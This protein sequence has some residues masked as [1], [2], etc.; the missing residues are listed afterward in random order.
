MA[1]R[2]AIRS[3]SVARTGVDGAPPV[4]V[5][6]NNARGRG[7]DYARHWRRCTR[8]GRTVG[9]T[10]RSCTRSGGLGLFGSCLDVRVKES[11]RLLA[12]S[13]DEH[14]GIP[15]YLHSTLPCGGRLRTFRYRA[16]FLRIVVLHCVGLSPQ[17]TSHTCRF[18]GLSNFPRAHDGLGLYRGVRCWCGVVQ[19]KKTIR[20]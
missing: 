4:E 11:Q 15:G 16:L 1:T 12:S 10:G 6:E 8:L 2:M 13:S 9:A 5:H 17:V 18:V 20:A 14:V 7:A 3:E 19:A